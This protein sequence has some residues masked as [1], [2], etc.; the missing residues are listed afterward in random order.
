MNSGLS[1][2]G[3]MIIPFAST[4]IVAMTGSNYFDTT[5]NKLMIYQMTGWVWRNLPETNKTNSNYLNFF[6]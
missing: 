5:T 3:S 1:P 2:T 4:G 6:S